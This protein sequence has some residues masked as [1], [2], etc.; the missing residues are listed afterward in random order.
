MDSVSDENDNDDDNEDE[1]DND[2]ENEDA[3]EDEDADEPHYA[4]FLY[5]WGDSEQE[6]SIT[7]NDKLFLI[8][9]NLAECL[10]HLRHSQLRTCLWIDAICVC[11][12]D[13]EERGQQVSLMSAIYSGAAIVDSW[14]GAKPVPCSE[15]TQFASLGNAQ[16]YIAK[17]HGCGDN[18]KQTIV[19]NMTKRQK[20][21]DLSIE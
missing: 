21:T 11:Q 15:A 14:L 5:E 12:A 2:N 10:L 1:N 7:L 19:I 16:E 8:Q 6:H 20:S 9:H 13:P 18:Y 17:V 4:A 3:D